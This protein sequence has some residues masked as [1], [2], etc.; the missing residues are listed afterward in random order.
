MDVYFE[1]KVHL[2][3]SVSHSGVIDL[4]HRHPGQL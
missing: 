2:Y 3:L 4:C 1:M